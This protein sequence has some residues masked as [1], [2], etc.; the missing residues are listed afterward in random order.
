MLLMCRQYPMQNVSAD[1]VVASCSHQASSRKADISSIHVIDESG[2]MATSS[3]IAGSNQILS[4]GTDLV[5][6]KRDRSG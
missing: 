2:V 3:P 1:Q 5:S 6:R 4:G